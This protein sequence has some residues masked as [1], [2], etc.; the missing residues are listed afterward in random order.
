MMT[1]LLLTCSASAYELDDVQWVSSIDS[2]TMH[3]GDTAKNDEYTIETADFDED[4][5]VYVTLY[6]NGV[7]VEHAPMQVGDSLEYRDVADGHDIRVFI[8]EVD[9][10]IDEWTETMQD[11]TANIQVFERG[12]PEFDITIETNKDT[13]DPRTAAGVDGIEV[14]VYVKNTG[15]AEAEDLT[16]TISGAELK[17][18][19]LVHPIT[20][21]A[22][23]ET[24][25][26]FVTKLEIPHLWE[27]TKIDITA[28]VEGYDINNDVH[29]EEEAKKV[30]I[31]PKSELLITKSAV[32]E[33][34]MGDNV[35]I[36]VS[37]RNWGLYS[38]SDIHVEDTLH[39]S[40]EILDSIVLKEDLSLDPDESVVLFEYSLK[41]INDGKHKLPA[42][43]ATFEAD[44][45]TYTAKSQQPEIQIDGPVIEVSQ[46]ITDPDI[47]IG[48]S[49]TVKVTVKNTGNRDASVY[50]S[51]EP[52][53]GLTF[54]S[55]GLFV[56]QVLNNGASASYSYV[57][58][59]TENGTFQIPPA[60]G[61]FIDLEN[62]KGELISN[63]LSLLVGPQTNTESTS[64]DSSSSSSDNSDSDS[65]NDPIFTLGDPVESD[66]PGE[67][68]DDNKV[69]PGFSSL[70]GII[71]IGMIYI[72]KRRG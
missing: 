69:E 7:E 34:Y 52:P 28:T 38:I 19:K 27:E 46:S 51:S 53:D 55:G 68:A 65:K 32:D 58:E 50:F 6:K 70:I 56:D 12:L 25:E 63:S 45:E 31:K 4:G 13:Y 41:P 17:D 8:K 66:N 5:F 24:S 35:R 2:K 43:E 64:S 22:I 37:I 62:Y 71:V 54:V 40:F 47:S 26:T 1:T 3:W 29:T 48:E 23:D 15:D 18:G 60:E 10:D 49:S 20:D 14:T 21:L 61:S 30:T 16:L 42:T 57:V 36:T 44:G 72:F 33:A 11:P 67:A 39:S 9:L 59:A